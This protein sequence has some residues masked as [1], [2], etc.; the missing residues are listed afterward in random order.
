MALQ[1]LKRKRKYE[2]Q[3]NQIDGMINT[4]IY[5]RIALQNAPTN[6]EVLNNLFNQSQGLVE[7]NE[8]AN[9]I[10][11]VMQNN[12]DDELDDDEL[13]DEL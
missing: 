10:A 9:E 3:I 12:N 4:L 2:F 11:N 13:L 5:Q 7:Q 8:V 6:R 1:A